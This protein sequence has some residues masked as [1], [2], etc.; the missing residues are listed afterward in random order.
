MKG[1]R[2]LLF[3]GSQTSTGQ[4]L[5]AFSNFARCYFYAL[6]F[7]S[8]ISAKLLHLYAHLYS[9]PASQLIVW[10][11]T[12]FQDVVVL[13]LLRIIAQRGRT[14]PLAALGA[15]VLIPF[16]LIVSGMAAANFSVYIFTGAEIHWKQ[17]KSFTN[18][19]AAIRTLLTGLTG[20]LVG[21]AIIVAAA[22]LTGRFVHRV[23]GG[24]LHV[25]AWP[26]RWLFARVSSCLSPLRQRLHI[27]PI[28]N[29]Y[30]DLPDPE[31]YERIALE[32]DYLNDSPD[33][34]SDYAY[35]DH[36]SPRP[37]TDRPLPRA[38][39]VGAF[40]L[41]LLLRLL[42][43]PDSVL[44]FLSGTLPLTTVFQGGHRDS[45]IDLTGVPLGYSYLDG[46]ETLQP[47]PKWSWMPKDPGP[48]FTD[49]K[50]DNHDLHY[51]NAKNPIHIS[52]LQEPLLEPVQKAVAD[53]NL[54][55]KHVVLLKLE[56]ARADIFP[57][58][59]DSFMRNRIARSY[60]DNQIPEDVLDRIGDLTPTAEYLTGFSTGFGQDNGIQRSRKA[61]GGLSARNAYTTSTYT[62]KSLEGTLCGVSPLVAD[63]N[64]EFEHHIYQPCSSQVFDMLT[65]QAEITN[66]TDNFTLWPWH[67]IWM[68]FVTETYDN[69]D[70]LMPKLGYFDK[71]T[72][73]TIEDPDAKHF[74]LKTEEVNYY[75]YA[76]T[77]LKEYIRDAIDDAE[78]NHERLFL[79]HLTGTTHHPWGLP[80]NTY[81]QIMGSNKGHN[82]DLNRYLNTIGFVDGWLQTI[83]DILEEK[84]VADE[85]LL[86]MAGDHG[87]SL[88]NDGGITPYD[89]PHV[90][91]FEVPI[92]FAH[93]K[94]PPI[95]VKAPVSS[96]QIVPSIIDLLI[97]SRSLP[98]DSISVASDIR[99]L[100][101]GQS[102]IWPLIQE[103]DSKQDWQF[104][105]MNTGGTWLSVR[106][107]ARPRFRLVIPLI[108]DVE[109][110]FTD[111]TKDP[112]EDKPIMRFNLADLAHT[113]RKEYDNE[114]LHWL[115]D[116]VYVSNW[117][118]KEN[119][120]RYGYS[121]A[122]KNVG[123]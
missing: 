104:T 3:S 78:S 29:Q 116:A 75:G 49:W 81:E 42:R 100:Y 46:A 74:P 92:V 85:T 101:E 117:W 25:L 97:E 34:E 12:F 111:L 83:L 8:V 86:V 68:Q 109:W 13:L 1:A 71:Q 14:R 114:L 57:L 80:N 24:L 32:D 72:K 91:N 23:A 105:V 6:A 27:F 48:G 43:P 36:H 7:W 120:N 87:L 2:T 18:D 56:S 113:I 52:N 9:L 20:F 90:G 107:A 94:L 118:V 60:K 69:Q 88:P 53:N 28:R 121:P 63:L 123:R 59:N 40:S 112:N 66:Q 84:G 31:V 95:E 98:K 55:I 4:T 26:L 79:T 51:D 38:L 47:P 65:R 58:R 10:S 102:L 39:I 93:P 21:E 115:F 33:D 89:N 70:K 11:V 82:E 16:S 119:W 106:S 5:D 30:K 22:I 76:D 45:P 108:N 99:S 122:P 96:I 67:S 37:I 61:Y 103:R 64:R 17:A 77:E 15:L 35:D 41:F 19:A 44:L 62:L 73:E 54:K 50:P 110:R